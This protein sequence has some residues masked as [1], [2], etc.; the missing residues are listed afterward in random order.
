M[1]IVSVPVSAFICTFR[2]ALFFVFSILKFYL[3]RVTKKLRDFISEQF[4][5]CR[6]CMPYIEWINTIIQITKYYS[7]RGVHFVFILICL[8]INFT[9]LFSSVSC[10]CV[11]WKRPSQSPCSQRY[12]HPRT[13]VSSFSSNLGRSTH[14]WRFS[15]SSHFHKQE[16]MCNSRP[17]S[18]MWQRA[19]ILSPSS[20]L[21]MK[22]LQFLF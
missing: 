13:R 9:S 11:G 22:V 18:R 12:I 15:N 1:K 2:N 4:I 21:K 17:S 16:R 20:G 5:S 6:I 3:L 14:I 8:D 19:D 7:P 10:A